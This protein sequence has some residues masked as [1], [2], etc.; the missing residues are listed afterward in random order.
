MKYLTVIFPAY[1]ESARIE[2]TMAATVE[3]FK[4]FPGDVEIML[5]DNGSDDDT[6][7]RAGG[8][9]LK[10]LGDPWGKETANISYSA[11]MT[12]KGKGKA[13]HYGLQR[14]ESSF[15]LISDVDLST[16]LSHLRFLL[17]ANVDLAIGSRRIKGARVFNLERSRRATSWIFHQLARPLLHGIHDSQCGFKL[18]T[19]DMARMIEPLITMEGLA[20][21]VELIHAAFLNG[22]RVAEIP[23]SWHHDRHST[24]HPLVD[25][26]IMFMDLLQIY[27][28]HALGKYLL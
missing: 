25:G 26:I 22:F 8:A 11:Y 28:N 20:F 4:S 19:A 1:N 5:I 10:A 6:Y 23:V 15:I 14:A 17:K 7:S 3:Y 16:P 9:V 24:I 21:D 12:E 18:L 13:I 2:K 27:H